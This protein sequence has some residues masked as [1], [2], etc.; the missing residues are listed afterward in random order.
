MQLVVYYVKLFVAETIDNFS[1]KRLGRK[2]SSKPRPLCITFNSPSIPIK[3][4][5]NKHK[6]SGSARI[7]NDS[8][9]KQR[10]FL[11]DLRVKLRDMNDQNK[12]IRYVNGIPKIV[13]INRQ[14]SKN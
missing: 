10:A 5:K 1:I 2:N 8:T 6:Y 14:Q 13:M 12:T 3:I 9:V 4:L 7:S 11:N